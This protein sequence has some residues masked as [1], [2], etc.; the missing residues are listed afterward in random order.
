MADDAFEDID[1]LHTPGGR[2]VDLTYHGGQ[3]ARVTKPTVDAHDQTLLDALC[4]SPDGVRA[5][6]AVLCP[7]MR[8][9]GHYQRLL[10]Q[11]GLMQVRVT[12]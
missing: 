8:A 3:V 12:G 4:A 1:G 2:D 7:S 6:A 9:I 5:D 10:T 11:A